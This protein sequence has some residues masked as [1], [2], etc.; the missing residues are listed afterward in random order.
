MCLVTEHIGTP[1]P[2]ASQKEGGFHSQHRPTFHWEKLASNF[3]LTASSLHCL[4][5]YSTGFTMC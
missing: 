1:D 4:P 5:A 3:M 2:P